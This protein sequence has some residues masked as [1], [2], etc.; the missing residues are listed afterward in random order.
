MHFGVI[1]AAVG[2][3]VSSVYKHEAEWTL[4]KG[5]AVQPYGPY[6][7]RLDSVWDV[8]EPNR[9]GVVSRR[10]FLRSVTAGAAGLGVLGW[11][12]AVARCRS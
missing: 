4:S 11:K 9:D 3:A 7:L 10:T 12:D 1:I 6:G 8:K 5:A 2:I